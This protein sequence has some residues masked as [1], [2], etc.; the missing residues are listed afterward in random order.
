MTSRDA[1]TPAAARA[2]LAA[3]GQSGV[4]HVEVFYGVTT[5]EPIQLWC[6]CAIARLHTYEEW[7]DRFQRIAGNEL[8]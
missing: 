3:D 2:R 1:A 4:K 8:S 5:G 6:E 7:V